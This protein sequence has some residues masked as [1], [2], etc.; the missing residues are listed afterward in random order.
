[1]LFTNQNYLFTTMKKLL[2]LAVMALTIGFFASCAAGGSGN[3]K[4]G[5]PAPSI[6]F[7]K[8]TVNGIQYNDEDEYCWHVAVTSKFAGTKTTTDYY[9][10]DTEFGVHATY[11]Y[12]A[13]LAAQ[14]GIKYTYVAGVVSAND[15]EDCL[16]KNKA[17]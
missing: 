7:E 10:W 4:E 12:A 5:D 13:W 16:S 8:G 9:E 3:Y 6:D 17:D 2:Y 11:E 15:S 1:M 14:T